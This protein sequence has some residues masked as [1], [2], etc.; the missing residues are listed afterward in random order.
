M[1]IEWLVPIKTGTIKTLEK[2]NLASVRLRAAVGATAASEIGAENQ[3]PDGFN[4]KTPDTIVIGKIDNVSDKQ[5]SQRWM[6][7]LINLKKK[8]N[9]KIIV[10]YTDHHLA[11]NSENAIFYRDAFKLADQVVCSSRMLT[12]HIKQSYKGEASVIQDPI[13]VPIQAPFKKENNIPTALW[14]GHATNLPYLFD[15]LLNN[16]RLQRLVRLIV[17]TNLYPFPPQINEHLNT[18]NLRN[19]ELHVI[20][21]S[22]DDLVKA[23]A[24]ADVCWI[25][26][27]VKD[28]RK[29]GASSNRLLTAI[30]LGLPTAAD[31]LDSYSSFKKY[32]LDIQQKEIY[33]QL[34]NP[35]SYFQSLNTGQELIANTYTKQAIGKKWVETLKAI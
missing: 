21:W 17:M 8:S 3:F 4:A 29:S 33:H 9:T 32:Y 27:G 20:P 2:S 23:S 5:R 28:P 30:S 7:R 13:E 26:A 19:L 16:Y 1:L 35:E 22:I 12:Q 14:F 6:E 34:A 24:L 10:D 25:P 31:N 18:E 15:F 11:S